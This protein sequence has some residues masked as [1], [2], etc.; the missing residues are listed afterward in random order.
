[1]SKR[2]RSPGAGL[3]LPVSLAGFAFYF[4]FSAVQGEYGVLRRIEL[5]AEREQLQAKLALLD[6]EAARMRD[7]A[8]RLSDDYLDLDLLD[9]RARSVLGVA[10]TDEVVID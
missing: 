6:A 8:L 5:D 7:R 10:R 9:E 3:I 1:M 2:R 4:A